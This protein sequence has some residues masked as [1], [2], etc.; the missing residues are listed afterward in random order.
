[1]RA[2]LA[3][4]PAARLW[5]SLPPRFPPFSAGSLA[6][7]IATHTDKPLA[8]VLSMSGYFPKPPASSP[9]AEKAPETPI[10]L[11]HGR[12]DEVLPVD[13]AHDAKA[14]CERLGFKKVCATCAGTRA[15]C[16]RARAE[17]L[18]GPPPC[19]TLRAGGDDSVPALGPQRAHARIA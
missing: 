4:Y 19:H 10:L 15:W 5:T 9:L 11:L 3:R 18:H 14:H 7:H 16:A 8:G 13:C 17:L 1:M 12:E 6:L 2:A